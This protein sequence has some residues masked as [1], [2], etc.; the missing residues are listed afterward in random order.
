MPALNIVYAD[1]A[2][3]I[4]IHPCGEHP[5]RLRGQGRIP[6]DGASGENDWT[7]M[8][9]R[10][11]LPLS[12]NP[13]QHFVASA[14]ARPTPLGYPHYLGWM[15]DPSYRMRR[16]N[17]MLGKADKLT[18]DRCR[19]FNSTP[20]TRRPNGLCRCLLA[21]V[22]VLGSRRSAGRA[23][24]QGIGGLGLCGRYR[25]H[26]AG[27]L[28]A[29]VRPLSRRG[30]ERRMDQPRHRAAGRLVGYSR[31]QPP[32]ADAGSA[33]IHDARSIR[34]SIW[35]DDRTTPE[36][37]TRDDIMRRSF[38]S[39]VASLAKDFGDDPEKMALGELQSTADRLAVGTARLLRD[40]G[41]IVGT[42]FTVNPGGDIGPVG[43]GASW[44]QI[45]DL[46]QPEPQRGRLSRRPERE[47][48][49]P[50]LCRS[51]AALGSGEYLPLDMVGQRAVACVGK[52]HRTR[53]QTLKP[54]SSP[55]D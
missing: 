40:G 19:P 21:C 5:L 12:I 28:A 25:R 10:R 41:P 33:R 51:D 8:V 46:A 47:P 24:R 34:S 9:P 22:V 18:V 53:F 29:L 42:S 50:T 11:E 23:G 13:S 55:A 2:G 6:M 30:V 26:R 48:G 43:G 45:V 16:I 17:D 39:A 32:R 37:E 4:A 20:T 52:I 31:R 14:N 54:L 7:G 3:N 49:Q 1:D 15:W 36:R 44:R 35:F 27:D 38:A